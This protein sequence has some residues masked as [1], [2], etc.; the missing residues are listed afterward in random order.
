M[1]VDAGSEAFVEEYLEH[2]GVKGMRWG[3]RRSPEAKAARAQKKEA[4]KASRAAKRE[5]RRK[6]FEAHMDKKFEDKANDIDTKIELHNRAGDL[7]DSKG[8]IDRINAKSEYVQA[9][10]RGLL[11]KDD[12]PVTQ[13]YLKEYTDTYMQRLNEAAKDMGTNWSGTREYTVEPGSDSLLGFKVKTKAVQHADDPASFRVEFIKDEDGMIIDFDIVEEALAQG[14]L[15]TLNVLKHYGVKG[16]RW[17]QRSVRTPVSVSQKGKKLKAKGGQAQPAHSDAIR[18]A[19]IGRQ[20][21]KSGTNSLSDKQ[22]KDYANRLEL[23]QRVRR[24]EAG[25]KSPARRF[26]RD[27]LQ[28]RGKQAANEVTSELTTRQVNKVMKKEGKKN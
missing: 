15:A 2:F 3:L 8:D 21:K 19:S 1:K 12:H 7:M 22:L 10:E 14:A 5:E 17:G 27:L 28:A 16:M 26:V 25:D 9:A 13:K 23:E 20:K 11:L 18:K 4:R 6:R 24:L